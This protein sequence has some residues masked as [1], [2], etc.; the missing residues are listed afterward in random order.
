MPSEINKGVRGSRKEIM[1]LIILEK[2]G[3]SAKGDALE[4]LLALFL[5]TEAGGTG[6]EGEVVERERGGEELRVGGGRASLE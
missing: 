3:R 6:K 5:D 1:W 4:L 2:F